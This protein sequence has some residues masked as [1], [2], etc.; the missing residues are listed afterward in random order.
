MHAPEPVGGVAI[1]RL[2]AMDDPVQKTAIRILN[3]LRDFV[4]GV[5]GRARAG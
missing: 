4:R 5:E 1:I 3:A 2:A